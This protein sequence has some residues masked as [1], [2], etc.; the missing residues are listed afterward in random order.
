MLLKYLRVRSYRVVELSFIAVAA[1]FV[2][3]CGGGGGGGVTEPN[4]NVKPVAADDTMIATKGLPKTIDVLANDRDDDGGIDPMSV[5]IVDQPQNGEIIDIPSNGAV[6]YQAFAAAPA[7][8]DTFSYVVRDNVGEISN[9][10]KVTIGLNNPPTAIGVSLTLNG[11]ALLCTTT[12]QEN[13]LSGFLRGEDQESQGFLTYKLLEDGSAGNGPIT[14]KLGASIEIINPTTGEFEYI[15][16]S[17]GPR[18]RDS[19]VYRVEDPEGGSATAE[20][21]VLIDKRIMPLGD[22]ITTGVTHTDNGT[23]FPLPE[24]RVGYRKA[25]FDSLLS[26]GYEID[27]AGS[28]VQ[29]GTDSSLQPFDSGNEGRG[30]LRADEIALGEGDGTPGNTGLGYPLDG[31]RKWLDDNPA[32]I[33]LLHI[34]INGLDPDNGPNDVALILDEID[35]WEQSS[36]GNPVAVILARIIDTDPVDPNVEIFNEKLITEIVQP[37]IDAGDNIIIVDQHS[38]LLNSVYYASSLHP[39]ETGYS[40][41]ADVWLYPLAGAGIY[42]GTG[43]ASQ[44]GAYPIAGGGILEKCD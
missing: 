13:K 22:S 15:P 12:R 43:S 42:S 9:V 6:V 31:V 35:N 30:G 2:V 39:N 14:T 20:V 17:S 16:N 37:R 34:G 19:F 4:T 36:A 25:L 28:Q 10:A 38:A 18:G 21:L 40:R 32:D 26:M 41:M 23:V 8:L 11:E 33:I 5:E 44:T 1:V 29:F 7:N 24:L 27:F 3:G